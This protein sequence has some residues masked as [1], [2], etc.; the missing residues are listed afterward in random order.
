MKKTKLL[1]LTLICFVQL[2]A[3]EQQKRSA[4]S[5]NALLSHYDRQKENELNLGNIGYNVNPGLEVLYGFP[6]DNSSFLNTGIS[7]QYV[8]I[9]SHR[10]TSDKFVVGEL[11]IPVL[12]TAYE[13][14]GYFSFSTGIYT[15]QFLHFSWYKNL[16]SQWEP[17]NTKDRDKYS[18]KSFFMDGYLDFAYSNSSWFKNDQ[19]IKI[20]P[21]IRY[22]FLDNWME[23]YRTSV[24]Y[25]IKFSLTFKMKEK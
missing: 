2:H 3:Q 14:S 23:Y 10:E 5:I 21:F 18:D 6:L 9:E 4:W 7:Y 16:H 22:R 11:S 24:Y 8:D 20:A 19:V 25:G 1:F 17:V 15:G 12:F 13:K